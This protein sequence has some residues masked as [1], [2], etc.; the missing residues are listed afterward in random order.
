MLSPL[1]VL[2][3]VYIVSDI[4]LLVNRQVLKSTRFFELFLKNKKS[5]LMREGNKS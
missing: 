2:F 3:Y 4:T 1:V 5:P